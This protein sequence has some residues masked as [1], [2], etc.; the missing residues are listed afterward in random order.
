MRAIVAAA[1]IYVLAFAADAKTGDYQKGERL[2]YSQL[3]DTMGINGADFGIK[4]TSAEWEKLFENRGE[5]FIAEVSAAYPRLKPTIS[6]ESF[7]RDMPDLKAFLTLYAK[8]GGGF[9]ACDR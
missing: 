5:G 7:I 3:A 2:F 1:L 8:D 9:P 6:K 4:H